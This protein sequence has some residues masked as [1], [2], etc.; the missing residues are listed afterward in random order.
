MLA[1]FAPL[2]ADTKFI[3]FL[4]TPSVLVSFASKAALKVSSLTSS[5]ARASAKFSSLATALVAL[6][7]SYESPYLIVPSSFLTIFPSASL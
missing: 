3:C 4:V 2:S 6:A 1:P 7:G 5:L